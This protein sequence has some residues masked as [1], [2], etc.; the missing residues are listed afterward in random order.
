MSKDSL[1]VIRPAKHVNVKIAVP[2]SKSYTNRALIAGALAEGTTTLLHPSQSED[3]KYLIEAL[4]E[5]SID[6]KSKK[7]RVQVQGSGGCLQAPA[8]EIFIGN[9]GTT[10]RFLSGLASLANGNTILNGDEQMQRRPINDLLEALRMAGI[11]CSSNNGYPP[12]II[13]GGNFAGGRIEV[14]GNISSQFLSSLL[15][16]AP[17][18]KRPVSIHVKGRLTSLPY[19]DMTLHVMR[20]FGAEIEVI[21]MTTYTINNKQ[22]YIGHTFP[23]EADASSATY[24]LA[25][26]AITGGRVV[27]TNL[28]PES[29][30]GDIKFVNVLSDMGCSVTKREDSIEIHGGKLRGIEVDMNEMPDCVPTLAIVAAFAE[31]VTAIHNIPQLRYKESNR[32]QAIATELSKLGTKVEIGDDG[33]AIRPQRLHGATIETYN[34]HRIAMSFAI[35]GLQVE[36][37]SIKNPGCV[38]KSFP[39]F[40]EE[41]EKLEGKK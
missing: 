5:F 20:S 11:K 9:A 36:G 30:Q 23:I 15:L 27:I 21:E 12:V 29:L 19:V 13:S 4:K 16:S 38:A 33:M 17:Y 25:A 3:S 26:A 41:F 24:F 37:I 35:A 14:N 28:S 22:K 1:R 32:L 2:P 34:D 8:K 18:A 31:G 7:D 6:I 10:M 40:W 39:N